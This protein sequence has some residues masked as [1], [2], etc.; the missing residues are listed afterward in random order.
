M[1]FRSRRGGAW[2]LRHALPAEPNLV[3]FVRAYLA[4]PVH[5]GFGDEEP[6]SKIM[7]RLK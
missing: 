3:R 5:D 4:A 1:L 2:H 6:I 7:E